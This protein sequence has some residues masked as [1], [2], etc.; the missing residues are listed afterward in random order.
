MLEPFKAALSDFLHLSKDALHIHFGI[1]AYLI[2]SALFRRP[3]G[4]LLPWLVVLGL[5]LV[6]EGLDLAHDIRYGGLDLWGIGAGI[7]DILNTMFWPT[8]LMLALRSGL[9]A[10]RGR[11]RHPTDGNS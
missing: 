7:K 8:A 1:A 5:E 11:P 9:V 3:A 6:N 2:A 4:S 10:V